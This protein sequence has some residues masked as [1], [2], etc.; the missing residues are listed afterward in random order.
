MLR[1]KIEDVFNI[2]AI[3]RQWA[4]AASKKAMKMHAC[5]MLIIDSL[6]RLQGW[7]LAT[8]DISP[9]LLL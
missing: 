7:V 4:A 8:E 9:V 5:D 3:T 2:S 1:M 6:H